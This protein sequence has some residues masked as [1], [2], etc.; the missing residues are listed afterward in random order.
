MYFYAKASLRD[1]LQA[2]GFA[3]KHF[4]WAAEAVYVITQAVT[5]DSSRKLVVATT[6]YIISNSRD[7][8]CVVW[9]NIDSRHTFYCCHLGAVDIPLLLLLFLLLPVAA[10]FHLSH[11]IRSAT[12]DR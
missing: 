8:R 9:A 3:V 11:T 5:T 10:L 2:K 6:W 4:R 12:T 7:G 1:P